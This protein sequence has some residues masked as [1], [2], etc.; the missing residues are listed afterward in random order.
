VD[1]STLAVAARAEL[2]RNRVGLPPKAAAARTKEWTLPV[3]HVRPSPFV[4]NVADAA[5]P[6]VDRSEQFEAAAIY[7]LLAAL[8]ADTPADTVRALKEE[9]ERRSRP[10]GP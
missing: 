9:L 1:W 2:C 4:I 10:A 6:T 3:V 5:A 8:P 7:A